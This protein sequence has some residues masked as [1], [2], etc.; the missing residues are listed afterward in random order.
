MCPDMSHHSWNR[1][2]IGQPKTAVKTGSQRGKPN[3]E[4]GE[5]QTHYVIHATSEVGMAKVQNNLSVMQ[6]LQITRATSDELP[7]YPFLFRKSHHEATS[8]LFVNAAKAQDTQSF[9][10]GLQRILAQ[11]MGMVVEVKVNA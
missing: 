7:K 5:S 3:I 4:L 2:T 8:R 1:S 9:S 10:P 11:V 6:T